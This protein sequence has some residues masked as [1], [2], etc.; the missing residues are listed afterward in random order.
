MMKLLKRFGAIFMS[1]AM[2]MSLCAVT[3]SATPATTVTSLPAKGSI[4]I[5]D[6]QGNPLSNFDAYKIVSWAASTDANGKVIY[7]KMEVTT[8]KN[9]KKAVTDALGLA[10]DA[11]DA[12]ILLKIKNCTTASQ[13]AAFAISLNDNIISANKTTN[14]ISPTIST[15]NGQFNNLDIGYYLIVPKGG[16]SSSGSVKDHPILVSLPGSDASASVVVHTKASTPSITKKI[17][18]D[19]NPTVNTDSFVNATNPDDLYDTSTAAVGDTVN[20]RSLSTIPTYAP[21]D[22]NN[23][24]IYKVTDSMCNGLY[25]DSSSI[26]VYVLDMDGK[27]VKKIL[28]EGLSGTGTGTYTLTHDSTP[29]NHVFTVSLNNSD[30]IRDWGNSGYEILVTYSAKLQNINSGD[31]SFGSTGNPNSVEL[32]YYTDSIHNTNWDT[33]ITYTTE[34]VITKQDDAGNPLSGATFK[35][36]KSTDNGK[37]WLPGV[38]VPTTSDG[39]KY[40]VSFKGLGQGYYKLEESTAPAGYN[41]IDPIFFHVTAMNDA[42]KDCNGRITGT[43]IPNKKIAVSAIGNGP[44]LNY[45]ATWI[46]DNTAV[47]VDNNGILNS[48]IKDT[49]FKLPGSGGMGTTLFTVGGILLIAIAGTFLVI[50]N[51]KRKTA[52]R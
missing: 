37:T 29:N 20:F 33:V 6:G 49:S 38:E 12:S 34:L 40:S 41:A 45:L 32:T 13:A 9:L 47:T 25:L 26:K 15:V 7:S 51:K 30:D 8:D 21:N 48:T 50:Y 31:V 11:T 24:I 1:I 4:T 52:N 19:K 17:V 42:V 27:T 3:A 5:E 23:S 28:T 43:L 10:S 46:S 36:S 14:K 2:I 18:I 16:I 35:L 44:A 39:S 22:T